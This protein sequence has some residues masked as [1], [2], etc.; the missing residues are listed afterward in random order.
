MRCGPRLWVAGL[1]QATQFRVS[2]VVEAFGGDGHQFAASVERI[3]LATAVTERVVLDPTADFVEHEVGELHHMK[4]IRD[5]GGVGQHRVE[6]R[7]IRARQIQ[8]RPPDCSTP[9]GW[10]VSE[11]SAR[12]GSVS[13]RH[14]IE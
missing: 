2:G 11:P 4:R 9:L 1:E 3:G 12:S 10:S 5:L 13:T 14:N 7:P 8:C 6:D